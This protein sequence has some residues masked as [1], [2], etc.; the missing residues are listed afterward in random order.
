MIFE[1]TTLWQRRALR[2]LPIIFAV[3]TLTLVADV[4]L[5]VFTSPS[6]LPSLKLFNSV[7]KTKR[8]VKEMEQ[9][10]AVV[11]TKDLISPPSAPIE[12]EISQEERFASFFHKPLLRTV[13]VASDDA[14]S[15]ADY[16]L[17]QAN[18]DVVFPT[19]F[20]VSDAEGTLQ[21]PTPS[22]ATKSLFTKE[23]LV[24]PVISNSDANGDWHP[25]EL[26]LL[27]DNPERAARFIQTLKAE[28]L[29]LHAD[30][31]NIDFEQISAAEKDNFSLWIKQLV[32]AFHE[33]HLLVT[34][35]TPL[36]DD[37]FDY[38]YL[39]KE[40]D[41]L[42][43]M[44]YD[45]HFSSE[46]AGSIAGQSW[47]TEGIEEM[48]AR[49]PAEKIIV[50]LGAYGYDWN[51]T[52]K[53]AATALSF[54]E[55]MIMA[56][57]LEADVQA[58]D[59]QMNGTFTYEDERNEKHEVWFLDA[60]SAWN[61]FSIARKNKV[62][63]FSMWRLGLED[64]GVWDFLAT[65]ESDSFDLA[66][67]NTA[68]SEPSIAF[69]GEGELLRVRS[70]PKDGQRELTFDD[71]LVDYCDYKL[72]PRYYTVDRSG[73]DSRQRIALT[74]DDGPDP[75]W[76]PE[77]LKVLREEMAPGTF[78]IVGD[79]AQ[80]NP[81]LVRQEFQ[82]GHL[83]GN[84]TF[85]HPNLQDIS[86]NRLSMEINSTQRAIESVTGRGTKLFR[87]PFDTDTTPTQPVQLLPLYDVSEM[88]FIIAGGDIDADDYDRPG[89]ETIVRN[90][91]KGIKTNGPNIVVMHDGG[92]D[93]HQTV[94][95]LKKLL[96][97][98]RSQGYEFVSLD[99]LMGVERLD[100]M[101]KISFRETIIVYGSGLITW[102]RTY[103][104]T[105]LK[106]LFYVTTSIS[107]LRILF[108]A[109]LIL[110]GP[111][112]SK[113]AI[114]TSFTP[115]VLVLIPAYNE[116][117][118]IRRTIDGIL[119]AIYPDLQILV[120]D[121]GSTDET[122]AIVQAYAATQPR[123]KLLV[124]T[125]GGKWSALNEGFKAAD[126]DYI[127]T[128][129]ADTIIPPHTISELIAPFADPSVDAV[130][131]NVQVGNVHNILTAFQ[132]VEYVTTQN[133]D[134][135]A[136]DALNC[137]SVVPGATGA[138]KRT[139]VLKAGGYSYQT[140]TEDADLTLTMLADGARIVY[141]PEARSV[142]E[143]PDTAITLFKQRV[144]WSFGTF[145]CFWK[146]RRSAFK[147]T[148]GW[149]ALPN[150][151]LFQVIYPLL[152]PIGDAV[153]IMCLMRRDFGAVASGYLTFLLMDLIGSLVA[154]WLD[155]RKP[156]SLW[157]VLIQR[158]YYR[159][160]MYVVALKSVY[161]ALKGG[162]QGWNKLDRKASV[163]LPV[164]PVKIIGIRS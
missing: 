163:F 74:F 114:E 33:A 8:V 48:V 94:E 37:A 92:G 97:M 52:T 152:S 60:I 130:C 158:F 49:V 28:I 68:R 12:K 67:L 145:Q 124:K 30:G 119:N 38:E 2:I 144:R 71:R 15:L 103:G 140:L 89:S 21:K 44:A 147:G 24:L 112:R 31:I 14:Q 35:D 75:K 160:F 73:H 90:V 18:L 127:V 149:V 77:I 81:D 72:I 117:K 76:T 162:R 70:V 155:G 137:I 110:R 22:A 4:L 100:L 11:N 148:L 108:L 84:H 46:H 79:Q 150:L 66:H 146:H 87:A 57:D 159:Q 40:S 125:N 13:F 26:A 118:V 55:T 17:H 36:N 53:E 86:N 143:A 47:F 109:A 3:V 65:G 138:W 25:N 78:F 62:R 16:A 29:S 129:D 101:P 151:F 164:I 61:E 102:S 27:M 85:L 20:T 105:I 56:G 19:W 1:K 106:V 128:I 5:G 139:S 113:P 153:F 116:A 82:E 50:A 91:L 83:L 120:V 107:I 121:D 39:G 111:Q 51:L 98:L 80:K 99:Q 122:V 59:E 95:A 93:R 156:T 157:V 45:E 96:P 135:R 54:A 69:T 64:P 10:K 136:F 41:A 88:G 23:H 7:T 34:V 161:L 58:K 9:A 63:G 6:F 126:R 123:V 43:I 134:R 141:A 104:W 142:T 154:Y 42:V 133:Y 115:P 131:G 32:V 132:D